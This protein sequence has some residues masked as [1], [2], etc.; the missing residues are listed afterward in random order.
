M[1][2]A[3]S[4]VSAWNRNNCQPVANGSVSTLLSCFEQSW[5]PMPSSGIQ[6]GP[7]KLSNCLPSPHWDFRQ[8]RS[9][10]GP[11]M[12][13]LAHASM[14]RGLSRRFSQQWHV[15]HPQSA[16]LWLW[17][18]FPFYHNRAIT[19]NK[20]CACEW[21]RPSGRRRQCRYHVLVYWTGLHTH[22]SHARS[23]PSTA[24]WRA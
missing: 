7:W 17:P 20:V 10:P 14:S 24:I 13:Q 23:R 3:S 5:S 6:E 4:F 2:S 15:E 11:L 22:Q 1:L 19:S 8:T 9:F 16:L 12:S 21:L 18:F